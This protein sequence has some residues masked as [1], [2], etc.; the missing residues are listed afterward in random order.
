LSFI[1]ELCKEERAFRASCSAFNAQVHYQAC[2]MHKG[3]LEELK[4]L[5]I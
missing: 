1:Q 4:L 2:Q 5:I 3:H